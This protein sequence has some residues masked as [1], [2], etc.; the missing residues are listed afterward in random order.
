MPAPH[1]AKNKHPRWAYFKHPRWSYFFAN[2]AGGSKSKGVLRQ[3]I[4]RGAAKLILHEVSACRVDCVWPNAVTYHSAARLVKVA[5]EMDASFDVLGL[6][7]PVTGELDIAEGEEEVAE[8]EMKRSRI[9]TSGG[10]P[11]QGAT[12]PASAS[13]LAASASALASPLAVASGLAGPPC[14][15]ALPWL[16][17]PHLL[18]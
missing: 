11:S 4:E 14:Q 8:L 15:T 17:S 9:D 3:V 10:T 6:P 16:P 13:A 1:E 5:K 18:C 7:K 12:Q 2:N